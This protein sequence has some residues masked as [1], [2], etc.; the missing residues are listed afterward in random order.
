MLISAP[1]SSSAHALIIAQQLPR[2]IPT[3]LLPYL[4]VAPEQR[5]LTGAPASGMR[6]SPELSEVQRLLLRFIH[7]YAKA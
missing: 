1:A 6:A 4:Y 7:R 2:S 3:A 5:E